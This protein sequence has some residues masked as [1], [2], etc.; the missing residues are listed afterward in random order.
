MIQTL[1][2]V[3]DI[4]L[5]IAG[6]LLIIR[7]VL[8]VF[9]VPGQHPIVRLLHV[10]TDPL[11][12]VIKRILGIPSYSSIYLS[13][14]VISSR[15]LDPIIALVAIWILRMLLVWILGLALV[16]PAWVNAP[17]THIGDMLQYVLRLIFSAYTGALFLRII[18]QWLQ[19]PYSSGIMRFLWDITEPVLAPV[20]QVLPPLMGFDLSPLIVYFLLSLLER[21]VLSLV[22]WVF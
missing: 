12:A 2:R 18:L 3:V 8:V 7:A 20:R 14:P 17:L 22:S 4:V 13:T 1:L 19:V 10:V 15:I 21:V 11:I 6:L 16:I 9:R 5:G